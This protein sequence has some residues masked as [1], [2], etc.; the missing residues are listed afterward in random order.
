MASP[1][2]AR[3][4]PAYGGVGGRQR[5]AVPNRRLVVRLPE[6]HPGDGRRQRGPDEAMERAGHRLARLRKVRLVAVP[7]RRPAADRGGLGVRPDPT[8]GRSTS[9]DDQAGPM[10]TM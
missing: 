2:S 10:T 8:T 4:R 7:E 5:A 1:A 9:A 3:C 6:M